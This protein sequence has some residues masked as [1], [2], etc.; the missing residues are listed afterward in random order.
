[1]V[2]E[3]GE[4]DPWSLLQ[5]VKVVAVPAL[6]RNT[7]AKVANTCFD[8]LGAQIIL[9][10]LMAGIPVVAARDAADPA[11]PGWKTLGRGSPSPGL[12]RVLKENL[13]RLEAL[14]VMLVQAGEIGQALSKLVNVAGKPQTAGAENTETAAAVQ[15]DPG[16]RHDHGGRQ[17]VSSQEVM[18]AAAGPAVIHL[19]PGAIVTPLARDLAAQEKVRLMV[20]GED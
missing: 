12:A 9:E 3:G 4:A 2:V 11:S 8:G 1:M 15:S 13:D 14:G 20:Q 7:A 18:A 19:L 5:D 10:A 6:T 17:L 16:V